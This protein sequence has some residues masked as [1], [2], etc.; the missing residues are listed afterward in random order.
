MKAFFYVFL[1]F[2]SLLATE[3]K[4]IVLVP[5]EAEYSAETIQEKFGGIIIRGDC[6]EV[7]SQIKE[8]DNQN[9]RFRIVCGD[10]SDIK[11]RKRL[12]RRTAYYILPLDSDLFRA[13]FQIQVSLNGV[14]TTDELYPSLSPDQAG[15]IYDLLV[16]TQ[17]V[18][19]EHNFTYWACGG[20]LLGAL[21][22]EGL[23]PWDDHLDFSF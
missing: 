18:F 21:R 19:E 14:P 17:Q 2:S 6:P 1:I 15:E 9:N 3:Q 16:K 20:T 5:K 12:N 23:I 7:I 4:I 8:L 22:H 13:I 11:D 10:F